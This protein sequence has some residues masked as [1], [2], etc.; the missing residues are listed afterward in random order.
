MKATRRLL[1]GGCHWAKVLAL[2]GCLT[3]ASPLTAGAQNPFA[4]SRQRFSPLESRP[5]TLTPENLPLPPPESH[6]PHGAATEFPSLQFHVTGFRFEGHHVFSSEQ[7]AAVVS[8]YAGRTINAEELEQARLAVTAY[9]VK[10]GYI[11]SGAVLED[12]DLEGGVILFKVIEGTL[13]EIEVRGNRWLRSH[14]IKRRVAHGGSSP[15]QIGQLQEALLLLNQQPMI[16]KVNAD[17]QPAGEAGTSRLVVNVKERFPFHAGLTFSN[18][19]PASVGAEH[20]DF[21]GSDQSLTGNGDAFDV[22]FGLLNRSKNGAE[23]GLEN[24]ALSYALPLS[25]WETM[26]RV[27]YQQNNYSIIEDPFD[28]LNIE[29]RSRSFD[30]SLRQ[31]LY[32]T[33]KSEFALS[34]TV[35]Q[36]HSES[37]LRG[38]R[39]SL[40]P[41]AVDGETDVTVI[42]FGQEWFHRTQEQVIALRSTFH[43]GLNALGATKNGTD[44][45]G[46]FFSWLSQA[47]YVRRL[48]QRGTHV[49]LRADAQW[50]NEQLLSLE[51]FSIGGINTV[52]GYRENQLVRDQGA[53]GSIELRVPVWLSG[54]GKPVVQLAAFYDIGAGWSVDEKTP[55]PRMLHSVGVGLI[56]TPNER[57]NAEVYWAHPFTKIETPGRKDLQDHGLNFR[58]SILAF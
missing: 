19:R 40:S 17:L 4:P 41:G 13:N 21:I 53:V 43:F 57:I 44:R 46:G 8:Q 12:Q 20:L 10:N 6:Q 51:Q 22:R 54:T 2:V 16:A 24:F 37:F 15:L 14:F 7:L 1:I 9:Y 26:L 49:I 34:L 29:G 30:I 32:R 48:D 42:R 28:V 25:S 56:L 23:S 47:Q 50:T 39:F 45:D 27:S 58:I 36:R 52:R 18:D 55:N 35:S 38:E 5:L 11:N 3:V 33:L 31:P